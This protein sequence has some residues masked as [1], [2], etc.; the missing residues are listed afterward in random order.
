MTTQEW[1]EPYAGFELT[2]TV[3]SVETGYQAEKLT[4]LGIDLIT[5]AD[6]LILHFSSGLAFRRASIAESALKVT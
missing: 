6:G 4:A 2:S 1:I 3:L 5:T